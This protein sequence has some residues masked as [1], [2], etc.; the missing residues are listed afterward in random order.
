MK[1]ILKMSALAVL[2][3][4]LSSFGPR[5]KDKGYRSGEL[6]PKQT[7][8]F[9]DQV[10]DP[11]RFRLQSTRRG[12]NDNSRYQISL[13]SIGNISV[14][15]I[16]GCTGNHQNELELLNCFGSI[17]RT[18]NDTVKIQASTTFR[19]F[20]LFNI[21]KNTLIDSFTDRVNIE[22]VSKTLT[23]AY[24]PVIVTGENGSSN[25]I[26]EITA[27]PKNFEF[28]EVYNQIHKE[29][30]VGIFSLCRVTDSLGHSNNFDPNDYVLIGGNSLNLVR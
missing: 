19:K 23:D 25:M 26:T 15:N 12:S 24:C 7:I 27:L 14:S 2:F 6:Q 21:Q 10:K 8:Y 30:T 11:K 20:Y 4:S 13:D 1:K 16:D 5:K 18:A 22:I 17:T 29:E 9:G 3:F 28:K